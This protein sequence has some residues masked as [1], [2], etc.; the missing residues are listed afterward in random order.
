MTRTI[1]TIF[2]L[3]VVASN[4]VASTVFFTEINYDY[5]GADECE[6]I[7]VAL[8]ALARTPANTTVTLYNGNNG[9]SYASETVSNFTLGDTVSINGELFEL[10]Y[11][12]VPGIQNG[13]PDGM[14]IDVSGTVNEFLSYEGTFTA[15]DGPA[16]G[17][18]STDIGVADSNDAGNE[19]ISL[20]LVDG[21][22][23]TAA[24]T[25]GLEN[26]PEPA[27]AVLLIFGLCGIAFCRKRSN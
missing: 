2:F 1:T 26:V 10:Y 11:W 24:K 18:M 9:Q 16:S 3:A 13:A 5:P 27:A 22:W 7:E 17:M 21:N 6:F 25:P 15:I 14:S 23:N 8:P 4:A 12:E 20:Q 19:G